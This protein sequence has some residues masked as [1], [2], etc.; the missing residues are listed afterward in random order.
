ME[1]RESNRNVLAL[2]NES[3]SALVLFPLEIQ[4]G[5]ALIA[6]FLWREFDDDKISEE[7]CSLSRLTNSVS[8]P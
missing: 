1:D 8:P 3:K 2:S 7:P 4:S 6:F 5:H